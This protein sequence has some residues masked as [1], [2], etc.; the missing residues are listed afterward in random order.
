MAGE[1]VQLGQAQAVTIERNNLVQAV[2]RPRDADLRRRDAVPK[3]QFAGAL[4]KFVSSSGGRVPGRRL[5]TLRRTS[6]RA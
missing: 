2:G 4:F 6:R 5:V 1:A 3:G